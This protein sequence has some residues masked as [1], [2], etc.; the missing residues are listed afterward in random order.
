MAAR[1]TA[2]SRPTPGC[3][4]PPG[5]RQY[6]R[7]PSGARGGWCEAELLEHAEPVDHSPVLDQLA[8]GHATDVDLVPTRRLAGGRHAHELARHRPGRPDETDVVVAVLVLL[9]DVVAEVGKCL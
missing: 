5:G 4:S 6:G 7:A 1:A 9:E 8:V 2:Y 3:F